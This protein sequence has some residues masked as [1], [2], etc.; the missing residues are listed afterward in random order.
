MPF[1]IKGPEEESDKG[2]YEDSCSLGYQIPPSE[3]KRPYELCVASKKNTRSS[4]RDRESI[5]AYSIM[6]NT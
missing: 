6:V 1:G 5:K 4:R 2:S 3:S